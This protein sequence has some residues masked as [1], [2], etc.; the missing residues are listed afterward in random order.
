MGH[1]ETTRLAVKALSL[2]TRLF[3]F[4]PFPSCQ[5]RSAR[6]CLSFSRPNTLYLVLNESRAR[7]YRIPIPDSVGAR[8]GVSDTACFVAA[9]IIFGNI[10]AARGSLVFSVL[11]SVLNAFQSFQFE[12]VELPGMRVPPRSWRKLAAL[13]VNWLASLRVELTFLV[14]VTRRKLT[15][16]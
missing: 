2:R 15:P 7:I 10:P 1:S 13:H 14:V 11:Q 9:L 6:K 16:A 8:S 3:R 12:L 5:P 4:N